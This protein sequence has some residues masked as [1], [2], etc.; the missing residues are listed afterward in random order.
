MDFRQ[1]FFDLDDTLVNTRETIYK[2]IGILLEEFQLRTDPYKIYDLLDLKDREERLK[3]LVKNPADFWERYEQLRRIVR[4]SSISGVIPTLEELRSRNIPLG[5]IT[6]NRHGKTLEKLTSAK[7]NSRIFIGGIYSCSEIDFLKPSS[8]IAKIINLFP[9]KV[10]YVGDDLIDYEFAQNMG[11][12]FYG[13]CT[14]FY[15]KEDF[16]KKGLGVERI[17]PNIRKAFK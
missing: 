17:F 8:E 7:I 15:G 10:L 14:G 3:G 4:V 1:I 5:I 6:N 11:V 13:V 16:L 2:R 12:D 9:E